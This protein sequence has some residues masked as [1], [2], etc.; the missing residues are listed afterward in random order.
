VRND[1]IGVVS[2]IEDVC[3]VDVVV[4]SRDGI[5][6]AVVENDSEVTWAATL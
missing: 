5:R 4:G 2:S 3:A 1:I 6:L